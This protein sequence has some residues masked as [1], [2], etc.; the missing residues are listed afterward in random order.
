[1]NRWVKK[2]EMMLEMQ[3]EPRMVA[4]LVHQDHKMVMQS[5]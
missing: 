2:W 4:A 1:M 5:A 3:L